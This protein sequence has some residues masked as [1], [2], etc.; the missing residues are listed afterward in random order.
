MAR[1]SKSRERLTHLERVFWIDQQVR[2]ERFPNTRVIAEHFEVSSRTAQR[3]IDFMRD[4]LKLPL[5]YSAERRGWYYTEHTYGL[6][7]IELTEGELLTIF[8]AERLARQYRGA[9]GQQIEQ[10][11][12]KVLGAMT[13]VVSIS[14]DALAE[15]YSFEAPVIAELDPSV[16]QQLGRAAIDRRRI[17]MTYY[18][19]ERGELT[20]RTA[21]PLHLRN[22]AGQWYLIAFDQLRDSVRDFH[23]SRIRELHLMDHRFEP[24]PDFNLDEYLDSG[25]SMIRGGSTVEAEII[26]DEYQARW[27]RE[28]GPLHPTEQREEMPDG[29]LRV[30]MTVTARDGVK[31]FVMQYGSH[32]RVVAPE[33]LRLAVSAELNAMRPIYEADDG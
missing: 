15:S 31:R 13:S 8:L 27:I 6:A 24:P 22:Y 11:F 28:R 2:A 33:A 29:G 16:F 20:R 23:I 14:L 32:A 5:D 7:A 1:T 18:S 4:R 30:R 3:T 9:A 25:F 10:A 17:E 26:F 21:D 12:A 19:A